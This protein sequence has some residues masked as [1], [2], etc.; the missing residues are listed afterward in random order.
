M[1]ARAEIL[2][3]VQ[4]A[5]RLAPAEPVTVPRDYAAEI[6]LPVAERV[7]LLVDRLVDYR[8]EVRHATVDTVGKEVAAALDVLGAEAIG[9]PP[10]LDPTWLDPT[11][12]DPTWPGPARSA[13]GR[14]AQ[15]RRKVLVD[16]STLTVADLAAL[17]AVVTA[18]ALACA[19]TGTIFLDGQPDQGRRAL[20][21]VPD[22]HVC[23]VRTADI[24]VDLP[25]AIRRLVPHRPITMVS[26]PSATSDIELQRVEGVHG[27][28]R[29]VVIVLDDGPAPG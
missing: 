10:G 23:I 6:D 15:G 8:A 21:L 5:A 16:D 25:S 26:G 27:P 1:T 28:R 13:R 17:D 9:V 4:D 20:S 7:D 22:A 18:S 12:L 29:L 24:V 11:W 2:R 14:A 3:R 19:S